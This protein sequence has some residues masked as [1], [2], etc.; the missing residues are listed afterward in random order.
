[1]WLSLSALAASSPNVAGNRRGGVVAGAVAGV[2]AAAAAVLAVAGPAAVASLVYVVV[3][4]DDLIED[5]DVDL[6]ATAV[7]VVRVVVVVLR[8]DFSRI[9]EIS[10]DLFASSWLC[11]CC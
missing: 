1:M 9:F 5:A 3:F 10:D 7:D 4:R 2:A 11:W 8:L 6:D